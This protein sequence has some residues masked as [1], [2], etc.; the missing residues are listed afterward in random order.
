MFGTTAF[1]PTYR[2]GSGF[3][4]DFSEAAMVSPKLSIRM[5]I[6][7]EIIIL[8]T[9]KHIIRRILLFLLIGMIFQD[10][11]GGLEDTRFEGARIRLANDIKLFLI[12]NEECSSTINCQKS[13][14]V[15]VSPRSGGMAVQIW[16]NVKKNTVQDILNKCSNYFVDNPE[17]FIISVD[18][19]PIGKIESLN[20]P[21]WKFA[22]PNIEI[23][24]KRSK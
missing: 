16:G 21:V 15:F 11:F 24:F 13:Q 14:I 2:A 20:L 9:K 8:M 6:W 22:K 4:H 17:L 1:G 7:H 19:Y 12:L 5:K 18:F 23:V 3:V 10:A